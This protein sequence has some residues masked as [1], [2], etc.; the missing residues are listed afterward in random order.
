VK[1]LRCGVEIV[2]AHGFV[3]LRVTAN[4]ESGGRH[5]TT[6]FCTF[7]CA[8]IGLDLMCL[9]SIEKVAEVTMMPQ[10]QNWI[11]EHNV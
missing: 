10:C 9:Q 5:V 2:K 6:A 8:A 4:A 7:F 11:Q 1:C 3:E